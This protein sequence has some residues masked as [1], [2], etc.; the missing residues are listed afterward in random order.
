MLKYLGGG[1]PQQLA[2]QYNNNYNSGQNELNVEYVL[3]YEL[4]VGH[5]RFAAAWR[6]ISLTN[7]RLFQTTSIMQFMKA[8]II[9]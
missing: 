4:I 9:Q 7:G 6:E 8:V 5:C 1:R 2:V 3:Q